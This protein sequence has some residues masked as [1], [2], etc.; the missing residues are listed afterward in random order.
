MSSDRRFNV[1]LW[2]N[3]AG[4]TPETTISKIVSASDHDAAVECA[5]DLVVTENPEINHMQIDT[6]FVEEMLD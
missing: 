3:T 6:W 2:V 4:Q 5:R 1:E